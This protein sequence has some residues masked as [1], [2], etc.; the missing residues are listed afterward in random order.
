MYSS[1]LEPRTNVTS[2][3]SEGQKSV[4][5]L[6]DHQ[7]SSNSLLFRSVFLRCLKKRRPFLVLLLC[8]ILM[9]LS[10][11]FAVSGGLQFKRHKILET[12]YELYELLYTPHRFQRRDE[13]LNKEE[14]SIQ[15]SK[16]TRLNKSIQKVISY[17]KVSLLNGDGNLLSDD[18]SPKTER[19]S[20]DNIDIE[21]RLNAVRR[22]RQR[23]GKG[24]NLHSTSYNLSLIHI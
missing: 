10:Y 22:T 6:N 15:Y 24:I 3:I 23:K 14:V 19:S 7:M 18:K 8:V 4:Y 9:S 16:L 11:L 13:I 1:Y 20:D 2:K 5:Y 17:G 21:N 12:E